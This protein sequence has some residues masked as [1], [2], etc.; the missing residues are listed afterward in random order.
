M[1]RHDIAAGAVEG[2]R[3]THLKE[4]QPLKGASR[5]RMEAL[6]RFDF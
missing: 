6:R 2:K 5:R 1:H 4:R 3:F